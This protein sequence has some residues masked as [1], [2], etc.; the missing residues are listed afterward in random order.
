MAERPILFSAPMI[1]ALLDGQKTQTRREVKNLPPQPA[2]SIHPAHTR[3]HPAPYLDA[4]CNAKCTP[5]NPRGKS[6]LWCWWTPD[7]RMGKEFRCPYGQPGDL[8]WVR[9]T[10]AQGETVGVVRYRATDPQFDDAT[11]GLRWRPSIHMRREFSRIILRIT[12]IR[13]ERLQ[14]ISEWDAKAEGVPP[15]WL[16]EDDNDTVRYRQPPTWRRGFAR[17]WRE[18]N[19]PASWDSNPYVWAIDFVRL[20]SES[21][22]EEIVRHDRDQWN[23]GEGNE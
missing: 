18:I 8:L 19:G 3:R 7:D 11:S 21:R 20:A 9:E 14:D 17:L 13:V 22:S 5:E 10:W 12:D 2:N 4:Y 6:D 16:D 1:Q 15:S 23:K